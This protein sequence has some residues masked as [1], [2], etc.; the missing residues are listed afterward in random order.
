M[1]VQQRQVVHIYV[2]KKL[3]YTGGVD[4]KDEPR[5][6]ARPRGIDAQK[7]EPANGA[8]RRGGRCRRAYSIVMHHMAS[9]EVP[10]WVEDPVYD[11]PQRLM[12]LVQPPLRTGVRDHSLHYVLL[13]DDIDEDRSGYPL[14]PVPYFRQFDQGVHPVLKHDRIARQDGQGRD[15]SLRPQ[16]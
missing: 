10:E 14:E 5:C 4:T 12:M 11:H 2:N 13:G 7:D 8:A 15:P 6:V 9:L 3:G 16:R 1:D